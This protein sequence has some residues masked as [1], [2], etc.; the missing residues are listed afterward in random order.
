[1]SCRRGSGRDGR[2]APA[3]PCVVESFEPRRLLSAAVDLAARGI[4]PLAWQGQTAYARAGEWV[5]EFDGIA[6]KAAK[7]VARI[8]A[9][10]GRAGLGE[11]GGTRVVRR[12]GADGLVLL[13][14]NAA[15]DRLLARL[16]RVAGVARV[17][18]NF[19]VSLASTI[20][21]DPSFASLY[22]L[23]NTGQTG[24]TAD[25]DIDAPEAWDITTGAAG[26][27]VVGVIDTGIDYTHPDLAANVW[28][29][30]GE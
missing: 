21:T 1:M 14:S 23:H 6:G 9:L 30:A 27:T 19:A 17:Q 26:N 7:Q 12:L 5:V 3:G 20:P 8:E 25:A 18:P 2:R 10:L 11:D 22:G 4:V 29:N 16:S 13:E 28:T 24:G 15:A